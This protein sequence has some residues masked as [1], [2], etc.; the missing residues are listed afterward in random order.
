MKKVLKVLLVIGVLAL[1]GYGIYAWAVAPTELIL[2]S[3]VTF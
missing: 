3:E 2:P 1:I